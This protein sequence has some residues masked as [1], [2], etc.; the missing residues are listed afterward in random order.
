MMRLKAVVFTTMPCRALKS[1]QTIKE[2]EEGKIEPSSVSLFLV[3][4]NRELT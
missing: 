3:K 2:A 4:N 1:L